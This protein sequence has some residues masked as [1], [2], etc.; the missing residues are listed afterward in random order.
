MFIAHGP[1]SYVLN[2]VIQK[3]EINTLSNQEQLL[4]MLLSI[5]FGIF[6]DIDLAILSMTNI[7]SFNHHLIFTHSI[8]YFVVLWL[9]LILILKIL[10]RVLRKEKRDILS[11]KLVNVIQISFLIG[12]RSHLSADILFNHSR[13]LFPLQTQI[14]ILGG[15]LKPNYFASYLLSPI[16]ATEL[17]AVS[18][19]LYFIVKKYLKD[20]KVV[21]Y[22]IVGF[23]VLTS[24]FLIFSI[25]MNLNTYNKQNHFENGYKI[26]DSDYDQILDR[27]D[28]D[29]NGNGIY[30]IYEVDKEKIAS[31]VES[32]SLNRYMVT[33]QKDIKY[34]FGAFNSYRL[35]SQAY[36]EQNLAIEPI[37]KEYT[38]T[39]YN[40]QKYIVNIS[41]PTTLYEYISEIGTFESEDI[42]GYR[43]SIF[44][45]LRENTLINMGIVLDNNSFG[46]VLE[47]DERLITHT[48]EEIQEEY[49]NTELKVVSIP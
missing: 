14:S 9:L 8:L 15:V 1:I 3:K 34:S 47:D 20:I 4:V 38:K 19:F 5:L 44:F 29:T 16:F 35:I 42:D 24:V 37:L 39:K 46:T 22:S 28:P 45:V 23:I 21:K 10:K 32:I 26:S 41:Y 43:G 11:D 6:P 33:T 31:F 7:P 27:Y 13:I 2:E 25:Y 30:N 36:F 18:I 49:P 17:V 12:T 48:I 40:I